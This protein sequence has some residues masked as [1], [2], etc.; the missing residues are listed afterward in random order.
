MSSPGY[1]FCLYLFRWGH[2]Y[3]VLKPTLGVLLSQNKKHR[4]TFV[5]S[6]LQC[7]YHSISINHASWRRLTMEFPPLPTWWRIHSP[8]WYSNCP[9]RIL[10][11]VK[12]YAYMIPDYVMYYFFI[13]FLLLQWNL[14]NIIKFDPQ[15]QYIFWSCLLYFRLWETLFYL[16]QENSSVILQ[17]IAMGQRLYIPGHQQ[18]KRYWQ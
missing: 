17:F 16:N 8:S 9:P 3:H 7:I 13:Q 1:L 5:H 10:L 18:Q 11:F 2:L 6:L 4:Y 12:H 14:W 15:P